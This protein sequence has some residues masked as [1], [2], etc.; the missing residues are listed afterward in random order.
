M[1]TF[2]WC[3]ISNSAPK[4]VSNSDIEMPSLETAVLP[5][6]LKSCHKKKTSHPGRFEER[7]NTDKS[8]ELSCMVGDVKDTWLLSFLRHS[9]RAVTI[10]QGDFTVSVC[11]RQR[12]GAET[13]S[14]QDSG[15][16]G[17]GGERFIVGDRNP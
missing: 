7:E 2:L 3:H 15:M 4:G 11:L 12:W 13:N 16:W 6:S 5:K 8:P 17:E 14:S 1:P 10:H 9:P